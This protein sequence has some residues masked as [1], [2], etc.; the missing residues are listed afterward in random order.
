MK[1]LIAAGGHGT[2]LRPITYT[3]NKHLIKLGNKPLIFYAVE[4]LVQAGISDI[5]MVTHGDDAFIKQVVGDGKRWGCR[6]TFIPQSAPKG[7][8][9]V[10]K[11]ARDFLKREKFV[12]YLGDNILKGGI[13]PYLKEFQ[14]ARS[15]CHILITSVADPCPFGV[16][17][18]DK[19]DPKLIVK[20]TEKPKRPA[21]KFALTGIY[22]FT[23]NVFDAIDTLKPSW[24]G[25]LE[26]TEAITYLIENNFQVTHSETQGWW[27]DTGK[28]E[29]MLIANSLVLKD[30]SPN[31]EGNIDKV[32]TI[33]GDVIIEAKTRVRSSKI[34]GPVVIGSNCL[35]EDSY[36]GPFTS[37]SDSC[38][39]INSE[40][41]MS[42][43][44]D[45]SELVSLPRRVSHSIVGD[46]VSL[47]GRQ[48]RPQS[49]R[50]LVG[51]QSTI[52]IC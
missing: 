20:L 31:I 6:V 40:I 17:T 15:H 14:R 3:R 22:F 36:I 30:I 25:E 5:A 23:H 48:D 27:K 1:G 26:I 49:L 28:P 21:S 9:H 12:F 39:V 4:K 41:E 52:D 11:V 33:I 35:I 50:F 29:D 13:D 24:R 34:T 38:K 42:I 7:L 16:P 47:Q 10:V 19:K 37:I 18:F 44:G 43:I 51:D 46:V 8:A 2:R 32:S 45:H